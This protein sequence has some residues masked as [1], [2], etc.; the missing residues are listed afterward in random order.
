MV[1]RTASAAAGS[2]TPSYSEDCPVTFQV[3]ICT[4][5]GNAV[6]APAKVCYACDAAVAP[7][8]ATARGATIDAPVLSVCDFTALERF[9]RLRF[10]PTGA[11]YAALISKYPS[12]KFVF[13]RRALRPSA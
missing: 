10:S 2:G 3:S 7:A 6:T 1:R 12:G 4:I 5:C 13:M 9:A 8:T 11:V